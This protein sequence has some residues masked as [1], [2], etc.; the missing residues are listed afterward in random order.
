SSPATPASPNSMQS[1][2]MPS[3]GAAN[4]CTASS[5]MARLTGFRVLAASPSGTMPGGCRFPVSVCIA[6]N[7]SAM[8]TTRAADW[9]LDLR[10]E[11]VLPFDPERA[12][13]AC[14][15][16]NRAPPPENCAGAL[17]YLQR[18]DGHRSHLPLEE[19]NLM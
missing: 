2:S 19:L 14:I 13:P 15:G 17:D 3:L 6:A 5:S 10:L 7:V 18:L 4:P 8:N 1:F 16:G 12:L 9:K 11:R